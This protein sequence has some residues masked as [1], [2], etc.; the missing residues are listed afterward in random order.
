[1]GDFY[2]VLSI[3][4][5]LKLLYNMRYLINEC[6]IKKELYSEHGDT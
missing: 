4:F 2:I 1:M 6:V 5:I 3:T